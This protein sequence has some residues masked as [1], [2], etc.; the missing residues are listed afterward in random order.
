MS[1]YYSKK[2]VVDGVQ[3][4][5]KKE[6][7]RYQELRLLERVKE[8]SRLETQK[9]FELIPAQYSADTG[10]CIE[11]ACNYVADFFYYDIDG[12]PVVEDVKSPA[13]KTPQYIIKR[14]LM[15]YR[16]D[17]RVREIG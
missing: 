12:K 4:D 8:I 2:C 9:R 16:Y 5:S 6:A 7:R 10:K 14:K 11:R 1:K 13:T 17:I 15:L 3:F